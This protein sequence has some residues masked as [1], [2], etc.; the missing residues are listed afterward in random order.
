MGRRTRILGLITL[1]LGAACVINTRPHLP[2]ED[3]SRGTGGADASFRADAGQVP[4]TADA[5]AFD[6]SVDLDGSPPVASPDAGAADDGGQGAELDDCLPVGAV[7][8]DG[9][10]GGDG[11]D[12][13][14]GDGGALPDGGDAGFT[15]SFGR[16]CD[17]TARRRDAGSTDT[18]DTTDGQRS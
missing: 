10:A 11:G 8:G 1:T 3:N 2:S 13:A 16:A 18:T 6:A 5:A 7:R 12:G 17:P 15:D 4:N 14:V 9:G